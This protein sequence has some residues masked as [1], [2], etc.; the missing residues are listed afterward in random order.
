[1]AGFAGTPTADLLTRW[2]EVG[3][4][5]PI[6]RD[7]T[8]KGTADQEPWVHGPEHEMIR[9]RYIELRYQ[10]LPYIYT[11]ME[12]M[13]RTGLPF[14]RPLFVEYPTAPG[15][16]RERSRLSCLG[17]MCLWRRWLRKC[18][19]RK[20]VHLPPGDWYDF[21]T[22]SKPADREHIQLHPATGRI[23]AVCARGSDFA[24]ADAGAEHVRKLRRGR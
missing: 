21:W 19:M 15:H 11:G 2:I 8:A 3:A 4:F 10:F 18:W 24:D 16:G 20:E 5:N 7:H 14:M 6:Y 23:A 17:A 12:E 1:M 9:R 22:S 13:T